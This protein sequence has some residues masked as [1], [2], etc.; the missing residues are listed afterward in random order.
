MKSTDLKLM[1]YT[2]AV[3]WLASGALSLG[4]YPQ[5]QSM[6]ILAGV[7]LHGEAASLALYGGALLV[8]RPC[9]GVCRRR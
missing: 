6:D 5:R 7:G 4:L 2:L 1:R 8:P 3:V 9:C